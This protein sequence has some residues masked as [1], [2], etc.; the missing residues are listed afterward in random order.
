MALISFRE[1]YAEFM[2]VFALVYFGG[3]AVVLGLAKKYDAMAVGLVYAT[4][5]SAAVWISA[6]NSAAHFNPSI[7]LGSLILGAITPIKAASY[8]ISQLCGSYIAASF[9]AYTI[10]KSLNEIKNTE[11]LLTL[12]GTP[13]VTND[14]S[15]LSTCFFELFGTMVA[16]IAVFSLTEQKTLRALAPAIGC[17]YGVMY[18][19][20]GNYESTSFNPFRYL[21]PALE[22]KY[23]SDFPIYVFPSLVGGVL[24]AFV[25]DFLFKGVKADNLRAAVLKEE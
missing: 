8:M 18:M 14:I 6:K 3:W 19:T 2:G 15:W 20:L 9:L 24:G 12:L 10:P 25:F 1:C 16:T 4:A 21:G 11:I 22:S 17:I 7:T 5:I 13:R 23:L